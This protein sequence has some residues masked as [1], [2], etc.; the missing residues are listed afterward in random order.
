MAVTLLNLVHWIQSDTRFWDRKRWRTEDGT[1]STLHQC[2][3]IMAAAP[4]P[5]KGIAGC[6]P[7]LYM[8]RTRVIRMSG[9]PYALS[10][11]TTKYDLRLIRI[12]P[13]GIGQYGP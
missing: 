11:S 4:Q 13:L 12:A 10:G 8:P 1:S 9:R 5:T 3:V 7:G 6:S 2:M